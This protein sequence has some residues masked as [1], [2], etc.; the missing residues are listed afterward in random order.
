VCEYLTQSDREPDHVT[1]YQ[2][3][4]AVKGIPFDGHA[5][6]TVG[7]VQWRFDSSNS[8]PAVAWAVERLGERIFAEYEGEAITI[9]PV[10]GHTH[11]TPEEVAAGR[12]HHLGSALAEALRARGMSAHVFPLLC[13]KAAIQSAREGGP[14][15]SAVL[16]PQLRVVP[17]QHVRK[18]VLIDDVVTSGGHIAA[19]CAVLSAAGHDVAEVAFTVGRTVKTK[20]DP[21][22]ILVEERPRPMTDVSP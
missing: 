19:A 12:V 18:V 8:Q 17:A 5:T 13:W 20:G 10:P 6:I 14:R 11:A 21:L 2:I 15:D 3:V 4:R 9:V 16:A 1:P 22:G 7:G